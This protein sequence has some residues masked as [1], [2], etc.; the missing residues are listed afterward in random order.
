MHL[1]KWIQ[2]EQENAP[3]IRCDENGPCPFWPVRDILFLAWKTELSPM[4]EVTTVEQ[5]MEYF[6]DYTMQSRK[7]F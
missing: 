2:W 7:K 3:I 5:L 4:M 1:T 6:G